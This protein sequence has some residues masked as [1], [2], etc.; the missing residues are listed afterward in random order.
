MVINPT[1]VIYAKG[2]LLFSD[3]PIRSNLTNLTNTTIGRNDRTKLF[4]GKFSDDRTIT[5]R[6][7]ILPVVPA[8]KSL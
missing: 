1:G 3:L 7:G 2:V 4:Q 6:Y 5:P 8:R